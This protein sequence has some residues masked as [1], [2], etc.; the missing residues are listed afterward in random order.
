M[1]KTWGIPAN[2]RIEVRN[3]VR[4]RVEHVFAAQQTALGGDAGAITA[5]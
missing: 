2:E 5:A 1:I 4:A 3:F